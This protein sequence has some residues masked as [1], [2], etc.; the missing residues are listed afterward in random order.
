MTGGN[1]NPVPASLLGIDG[2]GLFDWGTT[3]PHGVLVTF[4]PH[5]DIV[6]VR[7]INPATGQDTFSQDYSY[8]V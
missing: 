3:A 2:G 6:N 5:E 7:F 8:G 1:S 4:D